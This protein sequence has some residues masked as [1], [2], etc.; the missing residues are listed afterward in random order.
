MLFYFFVT[1]GSVFWI[2]LHILLVNFEYGQDCWGEDG[3]GYK[4]RESVKK[5][6]G[7]MM[8]VLDIGV[9]SWMKNC[10]TALSKARKGCARLM[11]WVKHSPTQGWEGLCKVNELSEAQP[12]P[13]LGR[14][15]LE[16]AIEVVTVAS[17]YH[18]EL[19]LDFHNNPVIIHDFS[20]SNLNQ[21]WLRGTGPFNWDFESQLWL[22]PWFK[23]DW[24]GLDLSIEVLERMWEVSEV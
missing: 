19:T 8:P 23:F 3:G 20:E 10:G 11:N 14:A 15:V 1:S 16:L 4:T 22:K 24:D 5:C 9:L 12:H 17:S 6:D 2:F 21:M 18:H 13:R 7:S